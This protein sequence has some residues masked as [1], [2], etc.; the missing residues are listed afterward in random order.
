MHRKDPYLRRKFT[1]YLIAVLVLSV[2]IILFAR[3]IAF[4]TYPPDDTAFTIQVE[5]DGNFPYTV[6]VIG[7]SLTFGMFASHEPA[8]FRNRLF[9]ALRERHPGLIRFT[10]WGAACTYAELEERWDSWEGD[11]DLIFIELG[12]NDSRRYSDC[13]QMPVE[14]WQTRVGAMLD[15]IQHDKPDAKI[16]VGTIAWC[17]WS[18]DS[19]LFEDALIYNDWIITE[20]NKRDIAVADLWAA[21]VGKR[22]GLSAPGQSSVFPPLYHGDNF[23]PNDLGHQRIADTFFKV[24]ENTL[25]LTHLPQVMHANDH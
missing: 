13:P 11:P 3:E 8:A 6:W 25:F 10:F 9:D 1:L 20:A 12:I 18:E 19:Q 16:I 7:D 22:D 2:F 17:G 23:H 14:A 5:N 15:R 4:A 21:T 24:Y